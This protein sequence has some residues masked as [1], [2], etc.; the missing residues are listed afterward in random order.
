MIS[1]IRPFWFFATALIPLY[2]ILKKTKIIAPPVFFLTLFDYS[3]TKKHTPSFLIHLK[4][5]GSFFFVLG[6]F[7][8]IVSLAGPVLFHTEKMFS[9]YGNP[10]MFVIDIS[11]SMAISDMD[12]DTRL[13]A[14]KKIIHDF[15]QQHQGNSYGLTAFASSAALLIPPTIDAD[16]FFSRL[17]TL[18]IGELGEGTALGMGMAVGT[19]HLSDPSFSHSYMV[20]LTDGENNTGEIH[21]YLAA[22]IIA[23]KNIDF[24]II[25]IGKKGDGQLTYVN[26]H[27]QKTYSG[28]VHT[29]FNEQE[30]ST[31]AHLSHGSYTSAQSSDRL[32]GVFEKLSSQVEDPGAAFVETVETEIDHYVLFA[33][34]LCFLLAWLIKYFILG[35]YI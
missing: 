18:S 34:F 19:A 24:F 25:G 12:G 32:K 35:V 15:A 20:V 8:L 10:I 7:L 33:A 16:S 23:K 9:G 11:P 5:T 3:E 14:A 26:P 28:S 27:N 22:S 29:V 2:S 13:L 21:P 4:K 1:F 17:E 30:L 6:F 31:I